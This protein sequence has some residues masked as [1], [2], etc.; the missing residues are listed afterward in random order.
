MRSTYDSMIEQHGA[1][2]GKGMSGLQSAAGKNPVAKSVE[3]TEKVGLQ[4]LPDSGRRPR[5]GRTSQIEFLGG[6]KY[7]GSDKVQ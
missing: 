5:K 2:K 7:I 6:H 1:V 3:H 4:E